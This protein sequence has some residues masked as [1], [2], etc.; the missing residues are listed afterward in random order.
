MDIALVT[1]AITSLRFIKDSLEVVRGYKID[2]QSQQKINDALQKTAA[3]QDTLFDLREELFRL[4]SENQDLQQQLK[5]QNDLKTHKEKYKLE[6]TSGGAF[7]WV[8][9]EEPVHYACPKC[10]ENSIHILQD[11]RDP[12]G[13]FACPSC[14]YNYPINPVEA[15]NVPEMKLPRYG[16]SKKQP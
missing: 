5:A 9:A 7:V 14:L 15:L 3:I 10:F 11:N 4:Q 8:S 2:I 16:F 13:T 6:K 12:Y 1:A